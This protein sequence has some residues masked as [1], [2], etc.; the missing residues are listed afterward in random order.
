MTF[1]SY[2]LGFL[3]R[4]SRS[5]A[6]LV[7]DERRVRFALLAF[8]IPVVGYT[9]VYFGLAQSGA[10]PSSFA[11]WLAI[12]A[13]G[14]YSVNRFLLA[15]SMF[16]AWILAAGVVQLLGRLVC[17]KGSFED[18]LSVLGFAISI[19]S[20]SLLPHDLVV[21]TLGG[22]GVI[23]G[24][25]HEHAMN[26]PTLARAILWFFMLVYLVAFGV[27]FTQTLRAAHRITLGAA[28][29]LGLSGFCVYQ[30]VFVTFNR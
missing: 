23:D 21:G 6:L 10:Y 7:S 1:G 2:Y 13:E 12:P 5:S 16:A 14:Y 17:A 8:A 22:L 27:L 29:F 24:R 28:T 25:A 30:L 4:P 9:L 15:P 26:A 20:W 3:M 18:T 19:A 11:P